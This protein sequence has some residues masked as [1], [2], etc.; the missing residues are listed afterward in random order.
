MR[1]NV[2]LRVQ[3][4]ETDASVVSP[5]DAAEINTFLDSLGG[6]RLARLFTFAIASGMRR[7]EILGLRWS[8]V[9]LDAD[10]VRVEHQLLRDATFGPPKSKAGKREIGLQQ[11]GT[12]ALRVQRNQQVKERSRA[13]RRRS[14]PDDLVFTATIGTSL[15]V[16]PVWHG[17]HNACT[18]AGVRPI[19]FHDLR[20]AC[21]TL[22]LTGGDQLEVI[23][24]V[25]GHA[26]SS[27]TL[28]V[29]AHLD[30][31]RAKVAASRIDVALG[32]TLPALEDVAN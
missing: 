3:P 5:W 26:D 12:Y 20:H 32:R 27:T 28:N 17:L 22:L 1:A 11:L 8:D 13:R 23:S 15:G 18:D 31:K 19:R 25:L 29:Y 30:P 16:R 9:D 6:G 7:G 14:N 10:T 24:K 21:A 4:H 2:C